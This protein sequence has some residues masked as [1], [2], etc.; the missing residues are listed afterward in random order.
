MA[1]VLQRLGFR[2]RQVVKAKP[3][4]KMPETDA[5]CDHVKKKR[6]QPSPRAMSN[7]GVWIVKPQ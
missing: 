7:A 6:R 4:K 5:I 1:E 2:L 3:Q